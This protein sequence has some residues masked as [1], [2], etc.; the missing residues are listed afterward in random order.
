MKENGRRKTAYE[1]YHDSK[2][3]KS[4]QVSC[5]RRGPSS[6]VDEAAL[7]II[8]LTMRFIICYQESVKCSSTRTSITWNRVT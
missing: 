8:L 5:I 3:I 7:I 2:G 1:Q 6:F 4:V